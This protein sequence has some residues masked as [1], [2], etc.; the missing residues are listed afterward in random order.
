MGY[1]ACSRR[2]PRAAVCR[3]SPDTRDDHREIL[4]PDVTLRRRRRGLAGLPAR[5]VARGLAGVELVVSDCHAGL[6]DVLDHRAQQVRARRSQGLLQVLPGSRHNV[7][8]VPFV[9]V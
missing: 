8:D 4:G 1:C 3:Q 9:L 7:I 2:S 5:S 6:R